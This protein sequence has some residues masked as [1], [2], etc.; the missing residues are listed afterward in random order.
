MFA[1][2]LNAISRWAFPLILLGIPLFGIIRGVKVYDCFIEGAKEGFG[3]ALRILPYLVAIFSAL[4]VF[5]ASGM[6]TFITSTIGP[7]LAQVGIPPEM[8]PLFMIRP[9]SGSGALAVTGDIMRT[10]GP[11]SLI[12]KMAAAVQGSTDTTFY[13][14]TLYFGCIKIRN[15]RHVLPVALVGDMAGFFTAVVVSKALFG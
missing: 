9:L 10:A 8:I 7:M 15:T 5:K 3:L 2:L 12:G 13:V 11:D 1:Y 6:L 14:V 4:A